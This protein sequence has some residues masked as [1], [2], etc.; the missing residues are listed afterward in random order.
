MGALPDMVTFTLDGN[1]VQAASEEEPS[2]EYE[3]N[4]EGSVSIIQVDYSDP[5]LSTVTTVTFSD[6]DLEED[7]DGVLVRTH[8]Y[9]SSYLSD[10]SVAKDMEPEYIVVDNNSEYAYVVCQEN[11]A[12]VKIEIDTGDVVTV[13]SL[14]YKDY[15]SCGVDINE[16]GEALIESRPYYGFYMPDAITLF[17][18]DGET[19]IAT[20]NE[21]DDR[22]DW[23]EGTDFEENDCVKAKK[24]TSD[25]GYTLD[26]I[27]LDSDGDILDEY[28]SLKV[29]P[30]T[31]WIVMM[32]GIL[33]FWLVSAAGLSLFRMTSWTWFTIAAVCLKRTQP[34]RNRTTLTVVTTIL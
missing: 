31:A 33:I 11:N 25:F 1:Y 2:E 27:F 4:P 10:H 15:S 22:A 12:I 21:G 8:N 23:E 19:F 24:L 6:S 28:A 34:K 29:S 17:E 7:G 30:T 13:K 16:D 5:S 20:A 18:V 32:T 26:E 14:G 3:E 9:L